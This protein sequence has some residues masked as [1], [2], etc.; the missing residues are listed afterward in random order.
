MR[1]RLQA[2]TVSDS[3]VF[4]PC[5]E[6]LHVATKPGAG[7]WTTVSDRHV[8]PL[9]MSWVPRGDQTVDARPGRLCTST[10]GWSV[11]T[12]SCPISQADQLITAPQLGPASTTRCR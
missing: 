10:H 8:F 6:A 7:L 12:P 11:A 1:I 9:V 4:R 3:R 2:D 5:H